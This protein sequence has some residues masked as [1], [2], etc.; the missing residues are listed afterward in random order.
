MVFPLPLQVGVALATH[1]DLGS[2]V[3][4]AVAHP[5]GLTALLAHD[6]D[7][8]DVDELLALDDARLLELLAAARALAAHASVLLGPG[9]ALH[10]EPALPGQDVHDP[11]RAAAVLAV[12]HPHF[13]VFPDVHARHLILILLSALPAA[14]PF[15]QGVRASLRF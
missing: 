5:R 1:P 11:A 15:G 6:L 9:H 3:V 14:A 8:G 2:L 10:H 13:V 12:H 7:V 4:D